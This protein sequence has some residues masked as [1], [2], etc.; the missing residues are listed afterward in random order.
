MPLL[1]AILHNMRLLILFC[2]S[3]R[4]SGDMYVYLIYCRF[5]PP[6]LGLLDSWQVIGGTPAFRLMIVN[7]RRPARWWLDWPTQQAPCVFAGVQISGRKRG[8]GIESDWSGPLCKRVRYIRTF[9]S[10]IEWV[11]WFGGTTNCFI[12]SIHKIQTAQTDISN[13]NAL[14][15]N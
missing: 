5:P 4:G 1:W 6:L 7:L 3:A 9:D 2:D 8:R 10:S 15:S 13:D 12:S 11:G 14:G